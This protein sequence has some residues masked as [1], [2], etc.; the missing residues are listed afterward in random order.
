MLLNHRQ[1]H[2]EVG[3][4]AN[5]RFRDGCSRRVIGWAID[6]CMYRS[7][8][9]HRGGRDARGAGR[10]DHP[11]RRPWLPVYLHADPQHCHEVGW[12]VADSVSLLRCWARIYG[13]WPATAMNGSDTEALRPVRTNSSNIAPGRSFGSLLNPTW[14]KG[15]LLPSNQQGPFRPVRGTASRPSIRTRTTSWQPDDPS[16]F[17]HIC[18]GCCPLRS[19]RR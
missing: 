7:R 11:A 4:I 2:A 1:R 19:W 3:I 8:R 5:P 17:L 12:G 16:P 9:V 13:G 6:D 14:R 10:G 18:V 15:M